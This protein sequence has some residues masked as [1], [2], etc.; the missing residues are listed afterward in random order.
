MVVARRWYLAVPA[1]LLTLVAAAALYVMTPNHFVS[2]EVLVLTAPVNG[3]SVAPAKNGKPQVTTTNPLLNFDQGL[4]MS[5]ALLIQSLNSPDTLAAIGAPPG[6]STT[7]QVSNGSTNPEDVNSG[8][9]VFVSVDTTSPAG[10]TSI[11]K[12]I[13]DQARKQLLA[14]QEALGAPPSTYITVGTV[15]PPTTPTQEH[16]S[17]TRAAA[18]FLAVGVILS[19]SAAYGGESY[20]QYRRR[21]AG[22][23]GSVPA[24]PSLSRLLRRRARP[25]EQAT[26]H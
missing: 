17:K 6:G 9:F 2:S 4:G 11:A 23:N 14:R 18:A 5:A 10:A 8:P 20:A 21:R 1:F 25:A 24:L 13:G 12:A 19:L 15:V 3:G 7:V 16:K 22:G 26:G